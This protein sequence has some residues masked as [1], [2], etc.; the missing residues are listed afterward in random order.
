MVFFIFSFLC[1]LFFTLIPIIIIIFPKKS[2]FKN[3]QQIPHY[4][5]AI[6]MGTSKLLKNGRPNQFYQA[7]IETTIKLIEN[8]KISKIVAS[9]SVTQR[10]NEVSDIIESLQK[11]G[12]S[13]ELIYSDTQGINTHKSLLNFKAEFAQPCIIISQNF[14]LKRALFLAEA[15]NLNCIG[16]C[17]DSLPFH[18]SWQ[19]Y[20]REYFALWKALFLFAWLKTKIFSI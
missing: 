2:I 4:N 20:V 11:N 9:G 1:S 17:A 5:Y 6:L 19:T 14:H 18:K 15:L 3:I 13:E 7:R 10:G 12:V 8:Q 16:V